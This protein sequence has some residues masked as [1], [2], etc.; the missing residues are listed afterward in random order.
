[1]TRK[2]IRDVWL[3]PGCVKCC[4]VV[5]GTWFSLCDNLATS[6]SGSDSGNLVLSDLQ[7]TRSKNAR[8]D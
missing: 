2:E 4:D 8:Q 6:L 5:I 3:L 1:M 7:G